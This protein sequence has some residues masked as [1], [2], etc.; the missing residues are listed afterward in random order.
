M[1]R[2][3]VHSRYL[4]GHHAWPNQYGSK[5][6]TRWLAD[7]IRAWLDERGLDCGFTMNLHSIHTHVDFINDADAV[8]FRLT[9][10]GD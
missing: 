3:A 7:D 2:V 8:L 4:L 5:K 6:N 1:I 9:F 10:S